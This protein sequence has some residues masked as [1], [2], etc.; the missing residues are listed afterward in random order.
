MTA[1]WG[2]ASPEAV[3]G[4]TVA[5]TVLAGI[6]VALRIYTRCMFSHNAGI[7]DIFIVAAMVCWSFD[8]PYWSQ[9]LTYVQLVSIIL[10]V[11]TGMEGELSRGKS[12]PATADGRCS[13]LRPWTPC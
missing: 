5:F 6:F 4:V 3:N 11:C 12:V 7:D 9:T 2:H 8:P 10:A 1:A 13:V